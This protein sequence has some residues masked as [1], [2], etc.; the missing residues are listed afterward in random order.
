MA[1][2]AVV[3]LLRPPRARPVPARVVPGDIVSTEDGLRGTIVRLDG[4]FALVDAGAGRL[5]WARC[6]DLM[7]DDA[8]SG[9]PAA[10]PGAPSG[11]L[12]G[13]VFVGLPGAPAP[14]PSSLP[15]TGGG[16]VRFAEGVWQ[17]RK[18]ITWGWIVMVLACLPL[19]GTAE[20]SFTQGG[21]LLKDGEAIQVIEEMRDE[22]RMPVGQ[23]VV[24]VPGPLDAATKRFD[25]ITPALYRVPH[26]L[27]VGKARASTDGR[28]VAFTIYFD[29]TDDIA[30][31]GYEELLATI[32]SAGY[33][34]DEFQIAGTMAVFA[35]TTALSKRDL[36]KAEAIGTPLAL[37]VLLFVFGTVVAASIPLLVG[38]T[39]VV[40]T[41]AI[42]HVLSIPL[43]LSIF[44][45]NI[46]SMLGFGLGIDYSLL[47]VSRF[48]E[49]LAAGRTVREATITTVATS[50]RAA[51]ISGVAVIAGI[52]ALAAMPLPIMFAI[53]LG[54][55]VVVAVT[56]LASLTLLPAVLGL[57]GHRVEK[58]TVRRVQVDRDPT[59]TG[60]Y[61]LAHL[62]MKKPGL[63]IFG[64]IAILVVLASP[65]LGAHLDVPHDDILP[66]DSLSMVAK[67]Q[68]ES[69][70]DE[71]VESPVI[72]IAST[73]KQAEL[74][75]IEAQLLGV[76]H[77]R[78]TEIV[79]IDKERGRTL[80]N[81]YGDRSLGNGGAVSR[82][83]AR[84]VQG[85]NFPVEMLVS[86][87]GAG[88]IEFLHAIKSSM[89]HT[90]IL[91]FVSTLI[92][93]AVA[94]R[95]LTLPFK[96]IV[97][98][99]LSIL[100]S[101]GVVIA[102][103]QNG[104]GID[105]L[106]TAPIG[107]TEAT[108]PII[109][110]CLLFGLSM[111]YEVFMLAKVTELYQAGHDDQEATARG[112]AATAPLVTGAALILIVIGIAFTTTELVLI[113]QI[114]FGMAVALA[115]DATIVRVLLLPAT[116]RWLGPANWWMPAA[117]Q[118]RVPRVEWA[119]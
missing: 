84:E 63:S 27:S 88:E 52:G 36:A 73:S 44:V 83:V 82:A 87:Q 66:P 101:L 35:D 47:G 31:N 96:A 28:L 11:A 119:H 32:E 105:L 64:G 110:F 67:R 54:G 1:A 116:M 79:K 7:F 86:G 50:G 42:L 111:D 37:L 92:V 76:E 13:E 61:R 68:L 29:D 3:F 65:T 41:L 15:D 100:A 99:T 112:V 109:L 107:Y 97:L 53:A 58:W 70:F 38:L 93:L 57:I 98:D 6:A 10:H 91:M 102:V 108:I 117:L 26:V 75:T 20:K 16:L 24:M 14:S 49:E 34:R 5:V 9:I 85:T 69:K 118:R 55:V 104:V 39:S 30:I 90:L 8:A 113:K 72:M 95:S 80:L 46:A 45:M 71:R 23:Q 18:T 94:F 40:V 114:G 12:P 81:A 74:D 4:A 115:L 17:A 59:T 21:F 33:D 43:G 89:P 25:K 2:V 60:W 78:R 48:R 22:F 19:A 103:F 77:I 106:G 51:A 56:V 62:V